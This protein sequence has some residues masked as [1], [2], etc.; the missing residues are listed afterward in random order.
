MIFGK[1]EKKPDRVGY[2][3]PCI[4]THRIIINAPDPLGVER[5]R[6]LVPLSVTPH[7][8]TKGHAEGVDPEW[9]SGNRRK[10]L[11]RN[12]GRRKVAQGAQDRQHGG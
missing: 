10:G 12:R 8:R 2:P 7:A 3:D 9:V 4:P 5:P 6:S 11:P 1:R